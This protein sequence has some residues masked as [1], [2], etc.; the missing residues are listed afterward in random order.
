MNA[1]VLRD[2]ALIAKLWTTLARV[3]FHVAKDAAASTSPECSLRKV[4]YA[5][6]VSPSMRS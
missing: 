4:P 2:K 1:A 5:L 3:F 6:G